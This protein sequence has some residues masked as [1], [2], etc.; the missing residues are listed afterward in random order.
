MYAYM[1]VYIYIL[2]DSKIYILWVIYMYMYICI[3]IYIIYFY[4]FIYLV[5]YLF[6]YIS[7]SLI[8]YIYYV[9]L[10]LHQDNSRADLWKHS[11][12]GRLCPN[13]HG[14]RPR[15]RAG[16]L[17]N[18]PTWALGR[19]KATIIW[20]TNLKHPTNHGENHD[21]HGFWDVLI[22]SL[23]NMNGGNA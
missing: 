12:S 3:Y 18:I 23:Y 21:H 5:T 4:L 9:I 10:L 19:W 14:Q 20:D 1:Y 17:S 11:P 8:I 22:V 2:G 16:R 15:R 7:L 13:C 6:I